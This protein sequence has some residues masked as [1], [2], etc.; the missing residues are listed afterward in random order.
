M[1][2]E[3]IEELDYVKKCYQEAMR[4]DAP[5]VLSSTSMLSKDA[6]ID[7]VRLDAGV[8]FWVGITFI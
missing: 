5:A 8:A 7:G 6:L 3:V 1:S 4:R 2:L